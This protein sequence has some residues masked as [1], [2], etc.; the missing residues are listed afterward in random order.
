MIDIDAQRAMFDC[1]VKE[2]DELIAKKSDRLSMVAMSMLSDVQE[3]VE[4]GLEK[5]T[6]RRAL[7]RVKYIIDHMETRS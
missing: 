7:N 3:M 5:E 2:L 1:T 6:V 4:I